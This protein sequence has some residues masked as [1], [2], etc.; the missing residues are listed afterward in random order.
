MIFLLLGCGDGSPSKETSEQ[1]PDAYLFSGLEE[2]ATWTYRDDGGTWED[3]GY[4]LN[5]ESLVKA[6]HLGEGKIELRRGLRWA[7]GELMGEIELSDEAGLRLESWGL[8]F[9]SGEG[10]YPFSS[11]QIVSG[12]T[13]SGDWDCSILREEAGVSTYYAHYEN[14]FSFQCSGGGLV[15]TWSFAHGIGLV[16]FEG[17]DGNFLELVAPW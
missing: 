9:G 15:G 8:P 1:N 14:V 3:T 6:V 5:E 11:A 4:E 12:E 2:E 16:R 7:D 10:D 13:V 17:D